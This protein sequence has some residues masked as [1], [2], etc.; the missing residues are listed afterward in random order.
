M[1]IAGLMT[2][3]KWLQTLADFQSS[4]VSKTSDVFFGQGLQP[5]SLLKYSVIHC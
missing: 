4:D 2:L 3:S 5:N 1:Q